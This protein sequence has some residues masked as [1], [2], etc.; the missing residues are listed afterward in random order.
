MH[1]WPGL[2]EG[3][4]AIRT[5]PDDGRFRYF[6]DHRRGQ[7]RAWR[8]AA[9]R[10]RSGGRRRRSSSTGWQTIASRTINPPQ[11]AVVSV[12]QIHGG[13]TWNV[14]P[15][16][17]VLRGTTRSLRPASARSRSNQDPPHRRGTCAALDARLRLPTTAAI[18]RPS[19][20]LAET[21]P[22]AAT[23]AAGRRRRSCAPT[24]AQHGRG[25][26]R[27]HA[28]EEARRLYLDRQ[29]ARC[30]QAASCTARITTSTTRRCSTASATGCGWPKPPARKRRTLRPDCQI[31]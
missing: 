15:D 30:R 25:G 24:S 19:I 4:F 22:A 7:G 8:H 29:R 5:R 12:T 20:P 27:L 23:A 18:P 14:I 17:L 21:E 28:R 6:R 2:P 26:F 16:R 9:S 31:R 11:G 3:Q 13:D 10:H 1:N